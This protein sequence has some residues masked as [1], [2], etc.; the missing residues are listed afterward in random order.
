VG[1]NTGLRVRA[2]ALPANR[3]TINGRKETKLRLLQNWNMNGSY[4][5]DVNGRPFLA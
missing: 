4:V 5:V 3:A 1:E 2:Q